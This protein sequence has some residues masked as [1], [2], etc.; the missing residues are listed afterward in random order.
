MFVDPLCL[1][2][3]RAIPLHFLCA[4]LRTSS[5]S[6]SSSSSDRPKLF[7]TRIF[8]YA[9]RKHDVARCASHA[10]RGGISE[11]CIGKR[12]QEYETLTDEQARSLERDGAKIIFKFSSDGRLTRVL[13]R[14]CSLGAGIHRQ[15]YIGSCLVATIPFHPES[16]LYFRY[17]S[18]YFI[19]AEN[20][21]KMKHSPARW[22]G[23]QI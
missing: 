16:V 13:L 10:Y 15:H 8:F 9:L 18:R 20:E 23:N 12:A 7:T 22:Q 1:R 3:V 2:F 4:W 11:L 6:S 19:T 17:L 5:S 14:F 21:M